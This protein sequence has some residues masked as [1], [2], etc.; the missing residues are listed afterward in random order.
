MNRNKPNLIFVFPDEFRAQ[1]LG[2]VGQDPV[3][4]PNL[5]QFAKESKVL[6]NAV[7]NYPVCSPFR[8][9]LMTGMYPYSN[10]V[11]GNEY[12][13]V[14]QHDY[15]LREEERCFTDILSDAGYNVGY[16]G[17]WHLDLPKEGDIP[18]TEGWR[19]VE[20]GEQPSFWDAYTQPGPRRHSIDF[21]HSYGGCGRKLDPH[22]WEGNAK[23][24]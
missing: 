21:W 6:T 9:M 16:L 24:T 15:E 3:V 1:S 22:Y 23:I 8:A 10:S 20:V 11:I 4:T 18:F 7:S 14:I 5:D 13:G 17:K 2:F 12:S 19:D